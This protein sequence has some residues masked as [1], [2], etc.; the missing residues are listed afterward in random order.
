M[1]DQAFAATIS[2]LIGRKLSLGT[3]LSEINSLTDESLID[4]TCQGHTE[5]FSLLVTRHENFIY[6]MV[7]GMLLSSEQAEDVTQEVFLRAYRAIRRFEKKSSFKT[8]I[9]RIAYNTSLSHLKRIRLDFQAEP[10]RE[11]EPVGSA[12][13][14]A[15]A[16]V[17]K[18]VE[19]LKP[20][21]KAVI[22]MHYY[23]DLKYEEIA[24]VLGCPIGTVKIRIFR[25]KNE[26]K[27]LWTKYEIRL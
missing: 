21:L 4:L 2:R 3:T 16:A 20:E 5:A 22:M 1:D 9:Y 12:S 14:P 7:R 24:E 8:W 6:T 17:R 23:D 10:V 18:L 19:Q 27:K 25:A 11:I 15:K 13:Q 26:L